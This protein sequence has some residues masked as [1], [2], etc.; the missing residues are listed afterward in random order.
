MQIAGPTAAFATI[1]A[2][3][4][5]RDGLDGLVI[6]TVLA[7]VFLILMG[8]CHFGTLIK[9]IPLYDYDWFYIRNCSDYRYR[10]AERFLRCDLSGWGKTDRDHGKTGSI[11]RKYQYV[12]YGCIDC[13]RGQLGNSDSSLLIFS[14]KFRVL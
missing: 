9:F 2:G 1:V 11:Y 3:I 8:L 7:G 6:A 14:K 12:K 4:V 5:A 10:A 13:G